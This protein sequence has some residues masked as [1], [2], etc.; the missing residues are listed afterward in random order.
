MKTKLIAIGLFLISLVLAGCV[1]AQTPTA[2]VSAPTATTIAA[3]TAS[4]STSDVAPTDTA[5]PTE[6]SGAEAAPTSTTEET[7]TEGATASITGETA[8]TGTAQDATPNIVAAAN[9]FLAT[10]SDTEWESVLFDWSDTDQKQR[11]SNLP[12]GGFERDGLMWENLSETQRNAWLA[13]M[14]ATL[15][16]EGYNRVIAEW[17]VDDA[18]TGSGGGGAGNG[19]PPV[20]GNGGP[21]PGGN[22]GPPTDGNGGPPM[23]GNGGPP[24]GGGG[25]LQYGTQ[26]Y[27]VAIIGTP[28]ETDP[29]QWQWGGHHVTVNATIV[30]P[31]ISLTPSFIGVQP[32][33]Y[34]D[35]N[36]NTV[37]PLGDIED[38]AFALVNALDSTQQATVILGNTS[39]DL[40]LGPGQ[41]GKTIASEGLPAS[42]MTSDQQDA[43]LQLIS[44]YTGLANDEDAAVRMA[45]IEAELD[46]TYLAWY[47]STTQGEAAYF[48]VTGPSIVI[49]YASQQMGGDP[50]DHIHGIY[51]DPT[52]DYG[53]EYTQ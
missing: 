46:D 36:G 45:E 19:G 41:D 47:G 24:S 22:G 42:E 2:E 1:A 7:P 18:L 13:L 40:V 39:I 53:A 12:E 17:Q 32:A 50:S 20:D 27:W 9:A 11:W 8:A 28:S 25:G 29:W 34:T 48:R 33:I 5:A 3:E 44:H 26:Y 14:Q 38:E 37:R 43:F 23:D 10:L 4:P 15:S 16:T 52:N 21:P 49:E 31:N 6:E 51:R 35:A 30:G